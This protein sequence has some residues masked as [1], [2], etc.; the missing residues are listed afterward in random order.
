[1]KNLYPIIL[2]TFIMACKTSQLTEVQP[3]DNKIKNVLIH[4]ND[5]LSTGPCEPSIFIN[6]K[7]PQNIVAG[8]VLNTF[9]HSFDGGKTWTTDKLTSSLG[10]Y[11]D[12]VIS[13]DNDG[14]F[15]YLHLG[16]PDG[17]NWA[18][19]RILESI[20]IQK[21]TDGGKTWNDG[22]GIG[23]NPPKQQDK[24]WISI[25]PTNND[26]YVTWTQFDK[27]GSKDPDDVS[28]IL[29]SKS[30]DQGATWTEGFRL[31]E[32][33]GN[34]IDDDDT[35]EGAVPAAGTKGEVFVAWGYDE[36]IYFDR[37]TDGGNT[38]MEEDK[39]IVEQPGGWTMD[40][41][42]IGRTNG[43]PVTGVDHSNSKYRG[44]I[45]VNWAD[46]RN[47][48][49]NSDI[50][51]ASSKDQGKTWS[52]PTRVNTDTTTSQ[53]FFPWMSVD[54]KTGVIYIV[55]YDRSRQVGNENEVVL[56][57]STDGGQSFKSEFISESAFPSPGQSV[58]F[59][60]YNNISAFDGMVRPIWTRYDENGLSIWTALIK[61]T[62]A[63]K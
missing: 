19:S 13:A 57:Y 40:I 20:V 35:V 11:G 30:T 3:Y 10:V 17:T 18:S 36:K 56:A 44:T 7:N 52:V 53:Q 24:E 26:L 33:A 16:D 27:Y 37:S 23:T 28:L 60:D 62:L 51:I 34:C 59:G 6:P 4:Q 47:G 61:K 55:Y 14:N 58:F 12:P 22:A 43:M 31:S 38:W 5:G 9:H 46:T 8:A 2:L 25:N 48:L 54:P 32:L 41:S 21:S 63:V 39:V 50:F 42:G 45:Y 29:F 1:M 15:Y 49:N